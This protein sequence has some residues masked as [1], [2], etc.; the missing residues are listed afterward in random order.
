MT[1][2]VTSPAAQAYLTA[3]REELADLPADERAELLE[4][5]ELH[6]T[7]LEEEGRDEP[8]TARLGS[9]ADYA[10]E[11]RAAAGL[12]PRER[13]PSRRRLPVRRT[14]ELISGNAAVRETRA[15]LPA[16]APAWWVVRG[17]LVVLLPCLRQRAGA[18][19]FPVPA[20]GGHHALG[21]LLVLAA[22]VLSVALGR[23]RLPRPVTV[24][25][26]AVDLALAVAAVG[27]LRDAPRRLTT[28]TVE[29]VTPAQDPAFRLSPLIT[30]HGPV[31]DIY[32]YA[33]DG[34]PLHD[35]L[36][37]D[38]DGRPLQTGKQLWWPDRCKRVL[39]PP[40]ALDGGPV[41]FA[42]PQRYV[43]DRSA[44]DLSGNP[45]QAGQCKPVARVKITPP[46]L[47]KKP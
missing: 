29:V 27:V 42:Y 19:D 24:L 16:L 25:I 17:Y 38:Q 33:S 15:F 39:A 18:H 7:A 5:L 44:V 37:Y 22:V 46:P 34:T 1:A 6:L 36:L 8:L 10:A 2:P 45:V 9:A 32:P 21:A 14:W 12:P 26:V 4:D 30:Q 20:P 13:V 3:V 40:L 41:P 23:R 47:V 11:L 43:L 28:H 31:T 35:V